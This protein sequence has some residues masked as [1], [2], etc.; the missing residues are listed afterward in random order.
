M[1]IIEGI[2]TCGTSLIVNLVGEGTFQCPTCKK[3]YRRSFNPKIDSY[4]ITEDKK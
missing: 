2:C 1:S 4:E 3:I